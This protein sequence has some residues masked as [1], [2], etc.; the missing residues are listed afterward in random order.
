MASKKRKSS[1]VPMPKADPETQQRLHVVLLEMTGQLQTNEAATL[2]QLSRLQYQSVRNRGLQAMVDALT[3]GLPGRPAADPKL[4][5]L[6][7]RVKELEQENAQL[8]REAE[9][10]EQ[11]IQGL[12]QTLREVASTTRTPR[13]ARAS[14]TTAKKSGGDDDGEAH[15][16]N[17]LER[18]EELVTRGLPRDLAAIAVSRDPATLRRWRKRRAAGQ[19]LA[20]VRGPSRAGQPTAETRE[21]V[22]QVV[23]ATRGLVGAAALSRTQNVSR[24]QAAAIKQSTLRTME[25]ER[26]AAAMRVRV[27]SPGLIRGLDQLW[28]PTNG[29]MQCVL[30]LADGA[31]PYRTTLSRIERYDGAHVEAVLAR[32]LEEHGPPLVLRLDRAKAH[33]VAAVHALCE[34]HG[35]L[36]LHGPPR[37]PTYYGQLERQNA[38]HRAWLDADAHDDG[39]ELDERL[40]HMKTAL[41]ALWPR[42]TLGWSTAALMWNR[43]RTP[44]V[45]RDALRQRVSDRAS[46]LRE[47]LP[48]KAIALG[49]HHRLAIE[50]E[51]VSLGLLELQPGG[52]C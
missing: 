42:R 1:Y 29:G 18:S 50:H 36:V 39:V 47:E 40:R 2:L 32:D 17:L 33:D 49:T 6:T 13:R 12:T 46:R 16:S 5:E 37:C 8:Q 41:N 44:T 25:H 28:V 51:L 20:R 45:N 21:R 43:R 31:I 10:N 23:R 11:L 14:K 19:R 35:V 7:E 22:V 34:R 27:A 52:W 48:P 15:R 4:R 3:R 9:R 38:E 26:V 30:A 24:R